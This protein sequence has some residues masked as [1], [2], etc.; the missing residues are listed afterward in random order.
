MIDQDTLNRDGAVPFAA[1][2][3]RQLPNPD[4]QFAIVIIADFAAGEVIVG[5]RIPPQ[6]VSH[7]LRAAVE[8]L[9]IPNSNPH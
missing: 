6:L 1:E 3:D 4:H 9:A 7:V 8:N 2:I 5:T